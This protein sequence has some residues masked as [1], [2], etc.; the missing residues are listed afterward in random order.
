MR[1]WTM[2]ILMCAVTV[3]AYTGCVMETSEVAAA[4]VGFD[5]EALQN[6]YTYINSDGNTPLAQKGD[7]KLRGLRAFAMSKHAEAGHSY[8]ACNPVGGSVATHACTHSPAASSGARLLYLT[9]FGPP[10]KHCPVHISYSNTSVFDIP[11]NQMLDEE[12]GYF[13]WLNS[14]IDTYYEFNDGSSGQ[15]NIYQDTYW[16][17]L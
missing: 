14:A 13:T 2:I 17:N 9:C 11:W 6:I 5:Q 3:Y 15:G 1:F 16:V 8:W 4:D 10:S 7:I 12:V